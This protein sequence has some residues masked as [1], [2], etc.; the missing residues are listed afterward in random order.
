MTSND[1]FTKVVKF[2]QELLL[3]EENKSAITPALIGE[4]ITMVLGIKP[5]WGKDLDR[6]AVIDELI[7][8]FS[9]WIGTDSALTSEEGHL[10]WLNAARKKDW[11]YWQR[12]R[13]YL[14]ATLSWKA[15][16]A[17]DRATDSVLGMLED[18]LRPG[19]WD[20][21]GLVVGHVQSGK[22]ANYTGLIFTFLGGA[23]AG[24]AIALL[25]APMTGK[26]MQKKVAGVADK[27]V[28]K[29]EDLQDQV[30]RFANG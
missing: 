9:I 6:Q 2:V 17:T 12:Y 24:A 16:E 21:R 19:S 26:K 10:A 28:D 1:S 15:I 4:K 13:E 18:P 5:D 29:V 7:R 14:E 30:R 20:R 11:R 25:Y 27:V 23:I 8:R 22:T 3:D